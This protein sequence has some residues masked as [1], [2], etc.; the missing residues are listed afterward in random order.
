[1]A[2]SGNPHGPP[3]VA[4]GAPAAA[5]NDMAA[6]I[7]ALSAAHPAL[8]E[9]RVEGAALLGER[10]AIAGLSRRGRTSPGGMCRLVTAADGLVAVN[11]PRPSDVDLV[12]AWLEQPLDDDPW[13]VVEVECRRR[14]AV[15]LVERAALLGLPVALVPQPGDP[16][17][18][19]RT[20]RTAGGVVRGAP[21]V[22]VD[23]S[24]MWAGPLCAHLLGLAG[25]RVIKV[26]ST[27]RPDGARGGPA[28]FYDLLHAGHESVALDFASPVDLAALGRLLD[29]ADIVV[30]SSRPRALDGLGLGPARLL[31]ASPDKVWVSVTGYGRSGPWAN[32]VAFGDDAAAAAGMI[33][34]DEEGTPMFCGDALADPLAGLAGANAALELWGEGGG[35]LLDVSLRDVVASTLTGVAVRPAVSPAATQVDGRWV[36]TGATG[37]VSVADPVARVATGRAR[38]LGADT[39]RVLREV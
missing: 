30:E 14:A 27:A 18:R 39:D 33:L 4:P 20:S 24:S 9:V 25:F 22:V 16:P 31:G 2:L 26:E 1:M 3:R 21:G 38:D 13:T 11:L 19:W 36:I 23:L 34:T 5:A 28:A 35:G 29:S 6:N 8:R 10:A 12:A 37:P 15:E 17:A 32:R 7:A